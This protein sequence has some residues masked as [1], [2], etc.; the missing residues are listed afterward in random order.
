MQARARTAG[1]YR[2]ILMPLLIIVF[3]FLADKVFLIPGVQERFTQ[4]NLGVIFRP[5][6]EERLPEEGRIRREIRSGRKIALALGSS[7]FF[8][9][10]RLPPSPAGKKTGKE[11][12]D[13]T[14]W[15]VFALAM[16][17]V[18]M[19]T[20]YTRLQQIFRRGIRP[21][22]IILE[23]APSTLN[24]AT[25]LY[26]HEL[27]HAVP[28]SLA[29]R[30][31]FILPAKIRDASLLSWAFASMRY[32]IRLK[33][34]DESFHDILIGMRMNDILRYQTESHD[35]LKKNEPVLNKAMYPYYYQL[36][37]KIADSY[38]FDPNLEALLRV[39]IRQIRKKGIRLVLVYP[40]IH[41][42]AYA[43]VKPRALARGWRK[44][45]QGLPPGNYE[46]RDFNRENFSCDAYV[47]PA[48]IHRKC[49][50][51]FLR[52]IIKGR[53]VSAP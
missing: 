4:P 34:S 11:K 32:R 48:H 7:M 26:P 13:T 9:F 53:G 38:S 10:N 22:L 18:T 36:L 28:A 41:P 15:R 51:R 1:Y 19:L 8:G 23:F 40:P 37:R 20:H 47:D 46:Y 2:I 31:L 14:E 5:L 30:R 52:S 27:I 3:I 6:R 44:I 29:L 45:V 12:N 16:P 17:A 43:I 25:P 42:D 49:F 33:K 39:M 24:A 35:S 21:D 50:R